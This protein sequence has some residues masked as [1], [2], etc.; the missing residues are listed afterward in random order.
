LKKSARKERLIEHAAKLF[1][2][3]GYE[4]TTLD[5]IAKKSRI[6]APAIYYYVKSKD[7][8]LS[9]VFKRGRTLF[10]NTVINEVNKKTSAEEKI[11]TLIKNSLDLIIN[12][13]EVSYLLIGPVVSLSARERKAYKI[14]SKEL[15]EFVASII[16]D[17]KIG[18]NMQDS[19]DTTLAAWILTGMTVWVSRW[20]KTKGRISQEELA[21]GMTKFFLQGLYGEKVE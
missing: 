1:F 18:R 21:N 8:L 12:R 16:S 6:K 3:C 17:L 14:H 11:G 20:Y 10:E 2:K 19:V 4:K 9:L 7:Q 13:P 15:I 5:D